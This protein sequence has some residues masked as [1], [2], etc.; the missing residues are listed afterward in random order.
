MAQHDFETDTASK[1]GI[2]LLLAI[3]RKL[4]EIIRQLPEEAADRPQR[5]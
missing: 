5:Q 1:E 2:E 4:R 3:N